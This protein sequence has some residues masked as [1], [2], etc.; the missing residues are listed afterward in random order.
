METY[1]LF[2]C[3]ELRHNVFGI[4]AIFAR[5][6]RS[7]SNAEQ[8]SSDGI[9]LRFFASDKTLQNRIRKIHKRRKWFGQLYLTVPFFGRWRC[10]IYNA[11]RKIQWFSFFLFFSFFF[12]SFKWIKGNETYNFL[13]LGILWRAPNLISPNGLPRNS[14]TIKFFGRSS[15]FMLFIRFPDKNLWHKQK[16]KSIF[17]LNLNVSQIKATNFRTYNSWSCDNCAKFIGIDES[18][19]SSRSL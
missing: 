18:T 5:S 1:K 14:N 7:I 4:V 15:F 11:Y 17:I 8:P 9:S 2:K 13:S 12:F 3:D 19:L 6:I 10:F 16:L